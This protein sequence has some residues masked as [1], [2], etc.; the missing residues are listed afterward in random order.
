VFAQ[1]Y[2]GTAPRFG[3]TCHAVG[4]RQMITVGGLDNINATDYCDW[5]YKSVAIYDLTEGESVGWGSVFSADKAPYQV[6]AQISAVIGG[7]P[8]GNATK[9]LPYGGWS[10]TLVAS[11]FTGTTNQTAPVPISGSATTPALSAPSSTKSTRKGA[12]AGGVVGGIGLIAI[13]STLILLTRRYWNIPSKV[14]ADAQQQYLKSEMDGKGTVIYQSS[15]K[16]GEIS[17]MEMPP[18][19][20]QTHSE[21]S[22]NQRSEVC[23]GQIP[24]EVAGCDVAEMD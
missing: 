21:I 1:I 9:L 24:A 22:G 3:H 11:L 4:N 13:I 2:N 8:N 5:E 19:V 23:G 15:S 17:P 20:Y 7:G 6:N 14:H 12:I 10:N 16:D 18:S